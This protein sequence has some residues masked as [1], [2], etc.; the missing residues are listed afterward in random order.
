MF[1]LCSL[2]HGVRKADKMT[3]SGME[4]A[5]IVQENGQQQQI[6]ESIRRQEHTMCMYMQR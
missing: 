1:V 6:S 4:E 3:S 2:Q 5:G